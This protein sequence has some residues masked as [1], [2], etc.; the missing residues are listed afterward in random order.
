[1]NNSKKA[2]NI[3]MQFDVKN[4]SSVARIMEA[5]KK[6]IIVKSNWLCGYEISREDT[7]HNSTSGEE[8]DTRGSE[9]E[10]TSE[11]PI[12]GRNSGRSCSWI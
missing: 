12:E 4:I 8:C 9:D 6:E 7:I 3:Q 5:S 10:Q 2:T 11:Q 1:M